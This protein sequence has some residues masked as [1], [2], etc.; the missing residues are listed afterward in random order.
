L[1]P[2]N[3]SEKLRS[4]LYQDDG[5]PYLL[6]VFLNDGKTKV[7]VNP[8]IVSVLDISGVAYHFS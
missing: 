5:K 7:D 1:A 8:K 2:N 6:E 4:K 3:S